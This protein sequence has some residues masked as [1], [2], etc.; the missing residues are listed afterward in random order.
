MVAS[1][2]LFNR[3]KYSNRQFSQRKETHSSR[4][5]IKSKDMKVNWGN[6]AVLALL[7]RPFVFLESSCWK[8][9]SQSHMLVEPGGT[10]SRRQ[11]ISK[12]VMRVGLFPLQQWLYK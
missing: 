1:F 7:P 2:H 11:F 12:E 9:S 5:S 10:T 3:N 4:S 8:P 6:S